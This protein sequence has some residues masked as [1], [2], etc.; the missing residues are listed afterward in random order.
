[1]QEYLLAQLSSKYNSMAFVRL[2]GSCFLLHKY[3]NIRN[4]Y[5]NFLKELFLIMG[6]SSES[7][8]NIN[9]DKLSSYFK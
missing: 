4:S 3:Q 8:E 9:D 1:M 6:E 5:F 7:F 2:V